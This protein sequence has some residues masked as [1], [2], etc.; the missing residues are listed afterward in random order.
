MSTVIANSITGTE[1]F[2]FGDSL[3]THNGGFAPNTN[4]PTTG[5]TSHGESFQP[6]TQNGQ[7]LAFSRYFK[8][9]FFNGNRRGC[10]LCLLHSRLLI[11]K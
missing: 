5:V 10:R 3:V 1:L 6:F 4:Y 9:L 2:L 11:F 7:L 8:F